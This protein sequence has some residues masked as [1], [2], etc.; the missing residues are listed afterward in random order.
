ME[1]RYQTNI[2][3]QEYRNIHKLTCQGLV[4]DIMVNDF[5]IFRC[6][7]MEYFFIAAIDNWLLISVLACQNSSVGWYCWQNLWK[8][9]FRNLSVT[10]NTCW[11]ASKNAFQNLLFCRLREEWVSPY[12]I[13]SRFYFHWSSF[14]G[15]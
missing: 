6:C 1:A 9:Y 15:V 2:L 5:M 10:K 11:L 3:K 7:F 4:W 14:C 13:V 8:I 12:D